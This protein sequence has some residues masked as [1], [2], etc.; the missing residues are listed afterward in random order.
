MKPFLVSAGILLL[1]LHS[2][3]R[4]KPVSTNQPPAVKIQVS[5]ADAKNLFKTAIKATGSFDPDGS[6][7]KTEINLGDG[8]P[9]KQF[10][11]Q[12]VRKDS[13]LNYTYTKAGNYT[14]TITHTDNKGLAVSSTKIF[15]AVDISTL[16][17][18]GT[19]FGPKK[20]KANKNTYIESI[21]RTSAQAKDFYR[22]S[23]KNGDGKDYSEED[24]NGLSFVKRIK[25]KARNLQA[26]ANRNAIRA[27]SI[28]LTINNEVIVSEKEFNINTAQLVKFV[29]LSEANQLR[30][31]VQGLPS[32][33]VEML[34]EQMSLP[35]VDAVAPVLASNIKS[36]SLVSADKIH[37]TITDQSAVTAQVFN[38]S[39]LVATHKTKEFDIPLVEGEN[40]FTVNAVDAFGNKSLTLVL[41][42][43]KRDSTAPILSSN[44][45]SNAIVE[46]NR[47]RIVVV[48][49]S[50]VS[51]QVF[52]NGTLVSTETSKSFDLVLLEGVNNFVLKSIDAAQNKSSDFLLSNVVLDT[53]APELVSSISS[54][55][56]TNTNKVKITITDSTNVTTQIFRNGTLI[57]TEQSK[58]FDLILSEG[59][60]NFVLKSTDQ[61]QNKAADFVLSSITLDTVVPA[62]TSNVNSN[63]ITK[64]NELSITITDA[65][66][67]STQVF[68]NGSLVST[69]TTKTFDLAL[70]EGVNNFTLKT[71]DAAQ[72]SALDF[73][74]S[75]ITLDTIAPKL[76]SNVQSNATVTNNKVQI[77]ISDSTSVT[78]QVYENGA[79]IAT[80]TAKSF[81]LTLNEGVNNFTLKSTDQAENKSS[82]FVLSNITL[83]TVAPV[84]IA[85]VSSGVITKNGIISIAISD[86]SS[87]T[88]QVFK[89]GNLVSTEQSKTFNL[90]LA[91]GA[92]N[93]ILKITDAAQNKASDFVL[94]NI[95]LDTVAPVLTSSVESNTSVTNNRIHVT[96]S[97]ATSVTTQVYRDGSLITTENSSS[98]DLTLM[99]GVN[100][101]TLKSTDAAQ[102]KSADF[103]L[104]NINLKPSDTVVPVIAASVSSGV[105]T[106]NNIVH[107]SIEDASPVT[108]QVFKN[109]NLIKSVTDKVFELTLE[110]GLNSFALR[111]M[112]AHG[113]LS[114]DFYLT[115]ITLDSIAPEIS[116]D[117][118]VQYSYESLPQTET[119]LV[120][121]NESV[122]SI[123][124][125]GEQL[126]QIGTSSYSYTL[127]FGEVGTR[128]FTFVAVDRAG[129]E[130]V[131]QQSANVSLNM[132]NAD[133][134]APHI[135]SSVNSNQET[136]SAKIQIDITDQS[137]VT[138]KVVLQSGSIM[139][140]YN[141]SF[142]LYLEIGMNNFSIESIDEFGNKSVL[143]LSNIFYNPNNGYPHYYTSLKSN[144]FTSGT[145][146]RITT[147]GTSSKPYISIKANGRLV[148]GTVL[149]WKGIF[150]VALEEGS[151]YIVVEF[152]DEANNSVPW[153]SLSNII[154]DTISPVISSDVQTNNF[155]NKSS[156]HFNIDEQNFEH[157]TVNADGIDEIYSSQASFYLG[158]AEGVYRNVQVLAVDRAGNTASR[159]FGNITVDRTRAKITT[160][161]QD[162]YEYNSLPQM[163][164]INVEV[165]EP[166]QS[167]SINGN[168]LIQIGPLSY[169][170][171]VQF[172]EYGSKMFNFIAL[173]Y[174]GNETVL[175]TTVNI[176]PDS[177]APQISTTEPPAFITADIFT[178]HIHVVDDQEVTTQVYVDGNLEVTQSEK[179]F[180]YDVI[181]DPSLASQVKAVKIVSTDSTNKKSEKILAITKNKNPLSLQIV[182]PLSGSSVNTEEVFIHVVSNKTLASASINGSPVNISGDLLAVKGLLYQASDGPF[183]AIVTVTDISGATA[184]IEVQAEVRTSRVPAWDYQECPI[185]QQ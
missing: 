93:F 95:T 14:V 144:S 122:Q 27:K 118:K 131:V 73:T 74:L 115:N 175:Q 126:I 56:A 58:S 114:A 170:Y 78:T 151:N 34:V 157:L 55:T 37:I 161:F 146:V 137:A 36:D 100:N 91:E 165:N 136:N 147:F 106:K 38:G 101:F 80:Q 61:A 159:N 45:N 107:I 79:L 30:L 71:T 6:I 116:S 133:T 148:S 28:N 35:S 97:D 23:F 155:T 104:T 102:N 164:T 139:T 112:D 149:P 54:N 4:P 85:S 3:A 12:F 120:N 26:V 128:I 46:S 179:S 62:L 13:V 60:N 156:I 83:D 2:Y 90:Q 185:N 181:F 20:Y 22:I 11:S 167:V 138:T 65:S 16:T 166:V 119:I 53:T 125:N 7:V 87:V 50:V 82:D 132:D 103:V 121:L 173:D 153:F 169:S 98:F 184:S 64:V 171:T 21:P 41:N 96:I 84:L 182:S 142:E 180:Y 111:S 66:A 160:N 57:A 99:T 108:T 168:S 178:V 49:Q 163:E 110:E 9:A 162:N 183:S 86:Q 70:T 25:C 77:T 24:C 129:N 48:D 43:I 68:K 109:G 152:T 17:K 75:D 158:V 113:N 18:S 172:D 117:L 81:E 47:V 123:S 63:T 59:V 145:S 69:Q 124:I 1:S 8:S 134:T 174:A 51:T 140:T 19:I 42:N 92:N 88:T 15:E 72:N 176:L 127:Q 5:Y 105:I 44:V 31:Q 76:S 154:R 150:D 39:T 52:R 143:T 141:K 67:V 130:T 94:S 10:D 89:N 177:K 32:A 135:I 40:S 29:R 33:S